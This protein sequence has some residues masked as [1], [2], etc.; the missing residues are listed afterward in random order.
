MVRHAR[1]TVAVVQSGGCSLSDNIE[2]GETGLERLPFGRKPC[3]TLQN[4]SGL[5]ARILGALNSAPPTRCSKLST[6]AG[7]T[8]AI[9]LTVPN[10]IDN[11]PDAASRCGR[12]MEPIRFG[13]SGP[14]R[15]GVLG[16][17]WGWRGGGRKLCLSSMFCAILI[18]PPPL[19]ARP[20]FPGEACRSFLLE[21]TLQTGRVASRHD[22]PSTDRRV[23]LRNARSRHRGE[24]R[25]PRR[26]RWRSG[27]RSPVKP[28][29]SHPAFTI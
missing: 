15:S 8:E 10:T 22:C 2:F 3:K 12:N 11:C 21:H 27:G 7:A 6:P 25:Q 17:V 9:S 4:A 14:F 23:Q 1:I 19:P 26:L 18:L 28:R 5:A 13:I 24:W 29:F 20:T 16:R